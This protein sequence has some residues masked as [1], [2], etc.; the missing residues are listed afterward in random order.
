MR[1]D[2]AKYIYHP[3]VMAVCDDCPYEDCIGICD[4]YRNAVRKCLGLPPLHRPNYKFK[5]CGATKRGVEING[6]THTLKEWAKIYGIEC[7]VL[8]NRLNDG[9]PIEEALSR[10]VRPMGKIIEHDGQAHTLIEWA[11]ML[12]VSYTTL[13]MRLRRG[14]TVAQAMN[15]KPPRRAQTITIDGQTLTVGQWAKRMGISRGAIYYRL[16]RG[17]SPEEAVKMEV[18]T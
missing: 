5:Q 1:I 17:Y 12:G 3:D 11:E 6:E 14:M 4:D 15:Q 8:Y 18:K 13:Y 7:R 16:R 2:Y 9:M 10:P